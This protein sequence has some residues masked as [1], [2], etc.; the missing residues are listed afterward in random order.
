MSVLAA[1]P[2][3]S[4]IVDRD[5]QG[6]IT[7]L[8]TR[9]F[10]QW[11]LALKRLVEAA[12]SVVAI[13]AKIT[14]AL[15]AAIPTTSAYLTPQAGVYRISYVLRVTQAATTSSSVA[16]TFGWI[17]GGLPQSLAIAAIVNGGPTSLALGE[18]P[19]RA[20]KGVDLTYTTAYASVGGIPMQYELDLIVELIG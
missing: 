12:P 10:N 20:D 16:V 5:Q 9:V 13:V 7:G 2:L 14:P 1:P 4:A 17:R 11:L 3:T 6:Q 19:L 18:V 8:M 15:Q